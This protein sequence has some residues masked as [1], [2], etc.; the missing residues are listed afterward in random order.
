MTIVC[1]AWPA[2][3]NFTDRTEHCQCIDR[4]LRVTSLYEFQIRADPGNKYS[5]NST[6]C[7]SQHVIEYPFFTNSFEAWRYEVSRPTDRVDLARAYVHS[8]NTEETMLAS[9][10]VVI[11]EG[12]DNISS[13]DWYEVAYYTHLAPKLRDRN[14][15]RRI[16]TH[17]KYFNIIQQCR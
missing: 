9:D 1:M 8:F 6:I 5:V 17:R 16:F 12:N 14:R 3:V 13:R 4:M 2:S 15:G 7:I 10:T 11:V